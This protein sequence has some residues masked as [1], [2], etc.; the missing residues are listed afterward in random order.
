[1][2]SKA[3]AS[4][5]DPQ[6][7][8]PSQEVFGS[9]IKAHRKDPVIPN[10]S[11][12]LPF[13]KAI[14]NHVGPDAK[15]YVLASKTLSEKTNSLDRLKTALG[16]RVKGT[17]VGMTPHTIFQECL[18]VTGEAKTVGADTIVTLG[19]GSLSDAARF[20]RKALTNDI[21]TIA[22]L[23]KHTVNVKDGKWTGPQGHNPPTA[24]LVF[25]PTSLSAGEHTPC[26]GVTDGDTKQKYQIVA[27][28]ASVTIYD[29][30]LAQTTPESVWL[31]SGVRG[32]DHAVESI[33][34][35]HAF[36][37]VYDACLKGLRL[38]V[39]GLLDSHGGRDSAEARLNCQL[40]ASLVILPI[41]W[42]VPAGASHGIGHMMGPMGVGHGETSC[43]LLPAVCKYNARV[44]GEKQA[45]IREVLW[46]I[47][48]CR[49]LFSSKGLREDQA[50]LGDLLDVVVRALGMPRTLKEKGITGEKVHELARM[51]LK[52]T[53]LATNPVPLTTEEEVLKVL[54]MVRG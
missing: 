24:N 49:Q 52:D 20:V 36:P 53:W 37:E 18:E 22:Q 45:R 12:G 43:I 14:V 26:S 54:S 41:A 51:S 39:P 35:G 8:V 9:T 40:G 21:S 11:Y 42:G 34:S 25:I 31:Q 38:L 13:D 19:A 28:Q 1:M 27:A 30:W 3:A 7:P 2:S 47:T 10:I 33:L 17:R 29:P 15:V 16:T 6:A 46:D 48:L 32:I 44:T 23:E 5:R 4:G 50:D